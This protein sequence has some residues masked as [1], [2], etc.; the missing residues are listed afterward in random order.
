MSNVAP[1]ASAELPRHLHP[2]VL[3]HPD[4]PR[5]RRERYD[6]YAP[7]GDRERPAIVF[8]HGLYP[9][10]L[11]PTARDWPTYIGYGA[12]ATTRGATGIVLDVPLHDPGDYPAIAR[13]VAAAI[14][15]ARRE[16]TVDADRVAVWAF[17]GGGLLSGYWLREPPSWLRCLALSY[18]VLAPL[19]G[20]QVDAAYQPI[21]AL[22]SPAPPIVLSRAGQ[23]VPEV[24]A[25]V[26]PFLG[27]AGELGVHV[28]LIDVPEGQ[29]GFDSLDH[30]DASRDAVHAGFDAVLRHLTD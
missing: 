18:P 30:T 4:V 3:A 29:H 21:D 25:T 15:D 8:M 13:T 6:V 17:S 27:R 7:P 28:E 26:P 5:I 16:P 1:D 9:A 20:W 24:A 11:Q 14:E 2:F 19:P 22:E 23:D 10:E 12:T